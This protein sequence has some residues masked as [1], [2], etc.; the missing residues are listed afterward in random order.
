MGKKQ[1]WQRTLR[2]LVL[3]LAV[4]PAASP[5]ALPRE[6]DSQVSSGVQQPIW[7]PLRLYRG[8][9]VVVKGKLG[10]LPQQNLLIDTGTAPS[11][12]NARVAHDLNLHFTQ[13]RLAVLNNLRVPAGRAVLPSIEVGLT[14]VTDLPVMVRDLTAEEK[15]L[16][17][18]IA[19]IIGLDVL[20]RSD[21]RI[22]YQAGRLVLGGPPGDGFAVPLKSG[23]PLPLIDIRLN[24]QTVRM[25]VDTGAAGL[26]LFQTSA[27]NRV[28]VRQVA[29]SSSTS[30]L[31]GDFFVKEFTPG[32]IVIGGR[33][34]V[35]KRAYLAPD[36]PD[37]GRP[38]D[39]LM[40][41]GALGFKSI[42]FDFENQRLY[43][44][45]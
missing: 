5:S 20:A 15:N 16:G 17:F 28:P 8:Y 7:V 13:G 9:L 33:Q 12:V 22:D 35:L 45:P 43:L 19:A 39:G 29:A 24:G 42:S 27:V 40:G 26:V 32:D 3:T 37:A 44:R 1:Q 23:G 6:K 31:S 4:L 41:V 34:F 30:N 38:F 11:I 18:P 14:H 2:V 25:L 21:F 36:Q 10:D